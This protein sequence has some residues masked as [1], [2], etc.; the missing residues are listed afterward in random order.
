MNRASRWAAVVLAAA[1]WDSL[2]RAQ[3]TE[4]V[5][6]ATGG[7]QGNSSHTAFQFCSIS[8][9]G[10]FVAFQSDADNLVAGDTN[11]V[12][13]V[14]LRDRR[15]GTTERVSLDSAG[16]QGNYS[17]YYPSIST[18]GRFVAFA[19]GATNLVPGDTNGAQD[20]FVRDRQ[21]GTT[22]R[23]SVDSAGA[24][25]NGNS[26]G[27][28]ISADGRFV[29]FGSAASNLIAGDTN[30][31]EDIFVRDRQ[32]GTTERV[33]VATD[34]T[35][36]NANSGDIPALA[37]SISADGRFVAFQSA[38]S[39]LVAGDTNGRLDIF[40]RDRRSGTTERV[41]V[42]TD[43][44]QGNDN[45]GDWGLSISADGRFV[46]FISSATNLVSGDTNANNDVFVHDRQSGTTERASVATDGTQ[47][48]FYSRLPSIS[49]DGRFVA[50]R[51]TASNLVAGDTNGWPDV[52]VRDRQSGTTELASL[53]TGGAQGNDS[54]LY[55]SISADGRFV[56]FD[57]TASNLVPG[58]TNAGDDVFVRDRGQPPILASCFGDG[59]GAPCPCGN[60]GL[61]DHGCENS[62][63]TGGALLSA[64]GNPRL[65][66]D[67]LVLTSSGEK[68]TALS[69]FL[70]G[71]D[72][73]ASVGFGDGLRCVGGTLKHLYVE[74]ASGGIAAAP[75]GSDPSVSARSAALGDPIRW[76]ATRHYQT[77]YR[78]VDPAFC[79][80]PQGNTWNVSNALSAVW[81]P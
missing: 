48:N 18:D 57:S 75:Q 54:S 21:T 22:E 69:I 65:S 39:N 1:I 15:S 25:G 2:A 59:T 36:G 23:V 80:I 32:S 28:S 74:R 44:T 33:S 9:G 29:A 45:S 67:T 60:S 38:A 24:Q 77:Y 12:Q 11:G 3:T 13:D 46:A 41:S 30:G 55:S 61:A 81:S 16:T 7:A 5:S 14:F 62:S 76:G 63:S 6:V 47:A 31:Y 17:S 49:A 40:V 52:F 37:P 10:R 73:I 53:S 79:P 20:V 51:G 4:R 66:S 56:A 58:D 8:A 50:F 42:A 35:Q 72:L 71:S 68:P 34:G 64:S 43:G 78:D 70:Q 27:A 19:S 26:L